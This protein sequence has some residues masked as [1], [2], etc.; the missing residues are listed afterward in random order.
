MRFQHLADWLDWQQTLHPRTIDLGL[1][2]VREVARR[3][4][5]LAPECPVITVGGT[6]GKGSCVAFL[7]AMLRAAGYKVG[8]YT[9]PHL[10]RYNERVRIDGSEAADAE[11]VAAFDRIDRARGDISLSYFEFGTLAAFELFTRAGCDV[12]VLE[13]GLGGRLDAVNVIDADVAII[14]SV[15]LDH[16]DWLG[17]DLESIG[18]E[19]AGIFRPGRPA[20]FGQAAVPQSVLRLAQER[21]VPLLVAGRDYR[22]SVQGLEWRFQ[23][24]HGQLEGLPVPALSGAHQYANAAAVIAALQSAGRLH[25]PQA[26][27]AQGL[28]EARLAGRFQVLPGA[29]EWVL[30]VAHNSDSAERLAQALHERPCEGRTFMV[31]AQMRRKETEPVVDA[32]GGQV[33]FWLPLSLPDADA[34]PAAEVADILRRRFG[35]ERVLPAVASNELLTAIF[36]HARPGDRVIACGSFRTVEEVLRVNPLSGSDVTEQER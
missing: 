7:E 16:T 15:S 36:R 29:V 27:I 11:L 3:L 30:D 24:P 13:V 22:W 2:R 35:G 9:S 31:F 34:R 19:K 4:E 32:L 28:R 21:Q 23:G 25:V 18:A 33:D 6:N 8:S 26:A 20:V 14:S 17:S 1:E 12:W 5:L 10:L